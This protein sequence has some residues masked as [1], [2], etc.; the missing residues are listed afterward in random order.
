MKHLV[1]HLAIALAMF[2]IGTTADT[3]FS[4]HSDSRI[5]R[6]EL[7]TKTLTDEESEIT[8]AVFR[9][10]IGDASSFSFNTYYLSCYNYADPSDQ[11]MAQLAS[12]PALRVRRLSELPLDDYMKDGQWRI[13]LRVGNIRRISEN[14]VVVGGSYRNGWSAAHAY[15]YRVVREKGVWRVISIETI[16]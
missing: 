5:K 12:T 7:V 11:I 9:H 8:Q 10:Q 1:I 15:V 4:L 6:G 13:F 3:L 14:E 16:S 2:M